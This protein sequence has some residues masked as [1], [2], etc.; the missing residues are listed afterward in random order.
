MHR[1]THA[2][3]EYSDPVILHGLGDQLRNLASDPSVGLFVHEGVV[4]PV[5]PSLLEEPPIFMEVV[6][7]ER[8]AV[9]G[10]AHMLY[11]PRHLRR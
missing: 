3:I 2:A 5:Q 8:C 10:V 7:Q 9:S 1:G 6:Q 4:R 11:F